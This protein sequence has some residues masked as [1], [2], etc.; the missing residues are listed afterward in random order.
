MMNWLNLVKSI[1]KV[2]L[3][4]EIEI[5]EFYYIGEILSGEMKARC[6]EVLQELV[7][8][9][10]ERREKAT[11]EVVEEFWKIRKLKYDYPEAPKVEMPTGK[12]QKQRGGAKNQK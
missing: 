2:G 9:H 6:I 1:E 7:A 4:F 11:D 3:N 8:E 12:K 10:Q 5:F